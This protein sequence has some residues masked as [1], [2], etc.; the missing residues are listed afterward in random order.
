MALE[1]REVVVRCSSLVEVE[2]EHT[3]L[4]AVAVHMKD[5]VAEGDVG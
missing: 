4:Q 1:D 2:G 3:D 5:E